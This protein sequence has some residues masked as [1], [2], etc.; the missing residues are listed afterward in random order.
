MMKASFWWQRTFGSSAYPQIE[1]TISLEPGPYTS[2]FRIWQILVRRKSTFSVQYKSRL[3]IMTTLSWVNWQ[4]ISQKSEN[5]QYIPLPTLPILVV[6]RDTSYTEENW[7]EMPTEASLAS[8]TF[9]GLW[10]H[11]DQEGKRSECKKL[12]QNCW[13]NFRQSHTFPLAHTIDISHS[14]FKSLCP[15]F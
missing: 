4:C 10:W 15:I 9:W 3:L 5:T 13:L 1:L 12:V 6:Q 8:Y 11:Q 14:L 2:S 7:S